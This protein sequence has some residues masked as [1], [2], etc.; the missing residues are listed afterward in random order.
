MSASTGAKS[1]AKAAAFADTAAFSAA[2][3]FPAL[4]RLSAQ[5]G[6]PN[7]TPRAF[8]TESASLV[9]LEIAS[10]STEPV[11]AR[12]AAD[13]SETATR[14]PRLG[15]KLAQV[16]ELL[17]GEAGATIPEIMAVTSWHQY[18]L[19][20]ALAGSIAKKFGRTLASEKVDERGR[21]YRIAK[22]AI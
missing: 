22:T 3:P 6:L 17:E 2:L 1:A 18:T 20:G 16:V 19:R 12:G 15:S 9:R 7:F 10:R 21:V 13:T 8:A 14:T 5:F 11:E 4:R